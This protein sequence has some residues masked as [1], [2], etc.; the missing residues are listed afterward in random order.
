M[1]RLTVLAAVLFFALAGLGVAWAIGAGETTGTVTAAVPDRVVTIPGATAVSTYTVPTVTET[2]TTTVPQT[3]SPSPQPPPASPVPYDAAAAWN[4]PVGDAASDPAS[5][6]WLANVK[7]AGGGLTSDPSQCTISVNRI[8][9]STPL[10]TVSGK[11]SYSTYDAG[12]SSRVGHGQPWKEQLP[13]PAGYKVEPGCDQQTVFLDLPAGVEYGCWLFS[14]TASPYDAMNCYRYHTTAGYY[15]RMAGNP[16]QGQTS[17]G[18]RGGGT[19]YY[20]GLIVP[21]EIA[22]GHIDHALAW[23]YKSPSSAFRYPATKSDGSGSAGAPE[24]A[25]LQLDPGLTDA[26]LHALGCDGTCLIV[27]HALQIYGAF[28]IDNSGSTKLYAENNL[29]A[30]GGAGWGSTLTRSTVAPLTPS[31]DWSRFRIV[32]APSAP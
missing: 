29:T 18:G 24:G 30:N 11:G 23:A 9:S 15:G 14:G 6:S 13:V 28:L 21:A 20:A 2:V 12:D 19:P 17:G 5:A 22:Q 3:T 27:A 25:R 32:A 8:D 26:D 7:A 31:N 10:S 4:T 1:R 16:A